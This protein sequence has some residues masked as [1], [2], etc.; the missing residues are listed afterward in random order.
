MR[1]MQEHIEIEKENITKKAPWA[2]GRG[3]DRKNL[4][5]WFQRD[6]LIILILSGV[7]LFIIALPTKENTGKEK[8]AE[9]QQ[10]SV[11]PS[12]LGSSTQSDS[13]LPYAAGI[14][15]DGTEYDYAS[16]LEQKLEKILEGADGVGKV[17]VMVTLQ[18]T[19]ELVVEKDMPV[20]RSNTNETDSEGGTRIVSQVDTQEN[21]IYKTEGSNSEPY[22]VKTILPKVEGVL[23]VAQGAG[24]G[25]V[26]K[27][28]SEMVLAL[29]DVEAHKVKVVPMESSN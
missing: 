11:Q 10:E 23:V 20:S 13:S 15:S 14:G 21:T 3:L 18:S 16:Y 26:D 25:T 7:L 17:S 27:N 12:S 2:A 29:F 1:R 22:V 24:N 19:G 4:Q 8:A 6:N 28:I 5:K 9:G